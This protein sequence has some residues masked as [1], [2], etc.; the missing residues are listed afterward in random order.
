MSYMLLLLIVTAV[1]I[2]ACK[3][4]EMDK[5]AK[6]TWNPNLAIPL[7]YG[8]FGV[9]DILAQTDSNEIII[10]DPDL[11][12]ISLYYRGDL[13]SITAKDIFEFTENYLESFGI[14]ISEFN[15]PPGT[16]SG[17]ASAQMNEAF[18]LDAPTDVEIHEVVFE[19]GTMAVSMES[20]IKHDVKAEITFPYLIKNGSPISFSLELPASPTENSTDH[21]V[22][23]VNTIGDFTQNGITENS[24]S[25]NAEITIEGSGEEIVGNEELNFTISLEDIDYNSIKG[26]LGQEILSF[27]DSILLR[28][29]SNVTEG[30]FQFANP[31]FMLDIEN[32]FGIPVNIRVDDLKTI[33]L[34]TGEENLLTGFE[35]THSIAIPTSQGET[36]L[37]T[38][39]F[40]SDNTSNLNQIISPVPKYL[41]YN[42]GFSLN[43]DGF[44]NLNFFNKNSEIKVV[45]EVELPLEGFAHGF[46]F[47]DTFEFNPGS[48]FS[49]P[50]SIEHVMFRLNVD[51]GFPVE[52]QTQIRFLDEN[53]EFLFAAFDTPEYAI[54]S[55]EVNEQGRVIISTNKIS[56]ISLGT[57]E[58]GLL[59]KVAYVEILAAGATKNGVQEQTVKFFDD[60][61]IKPRL[62]I[63]VQGKQS[64]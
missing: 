29:F 30:D 44:Q 12:N 27:E 47:K 11:G 13:F 22:D 16:F 42:S 39:Q 20:N 3:K 24:L 26:Y 59:D 40:D 38:I 43:P 32:S 4:L 48:D 62:A 60:Y 53:H 33:T 14:N 57:S 49:D 50:A 36:A 23:L 45:G 10:I 8:E 28:I 1:S 9:Y 54:E 55:G 21:Q 46:A 2:V 64:F 63:Q 18:V 25:F 56:D 34:E 15:I 41:Y 51:N 6:G 31:R 19:Q 37:T 35:P 5:I 58:I 52:I 61:K 7:A 17:S